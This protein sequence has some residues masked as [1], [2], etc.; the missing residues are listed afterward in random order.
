MKVLKRVLLGASVVV[1]L[2][3]IA[4]VTLPFVVPTSAYKS[5][6]EARVKSLTGRDFRLGGQ[7]D[8]AV[9]SGLALRATDVTFGNR[10]GASGEPDMV[11]LKEMDLKLR[12]W[13]LL[14]GRFEVT[15]I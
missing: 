12:F 13:P 3:V 6:I 7:L 2:L 1:V 8:F 14:G 11:K 10:P 4:A 5:E 9:F 15:G